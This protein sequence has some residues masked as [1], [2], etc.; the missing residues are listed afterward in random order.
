MAMISYATHFLG[1]FFALSS[2]F[3]W[4]AA[5]LIWNQLSRQYITPVSISLGKALTAICYFL[6]LALFMGYS[7]PENKICLMLVLSGLLGISIGDTAFFYSLKHL[8]PRRSVL[9]T[10]FIPML[11]ALLASLFLGERLSFLQWMGM[12]VCVCGTAVVIMEHIP[13]DAS[14]NKKIGIIWGCVSITACAAS[15]L[16]SKSALSSAGAFEASVL[17]LGAGVIGLLL[18]GIIKKGYFKEVASLLRPDLVGTL[19]LGSFF[20]T[21]LGIWF[22]ILSLKYTLVSIST[23]LNGMSPVFILPLSCLLLKEKVSKRTVYG[24]IIAVLGGSSVL[25]FKV[26]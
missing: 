14:F 3:L 24:T 15:I 6:F 2:A 16:I 26:P 10:V 25:L 17:R 22:F 20:G 4:A 21:F 5:S 7:M 12:F 23:V 13:D 11:T 9:L 19:F 8:G 18:Y 1:G